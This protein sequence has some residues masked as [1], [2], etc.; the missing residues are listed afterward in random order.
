VSR[1]RIATRR[2]PLA[3]WQARH[4]A[5]LL[6]AARPG[7]EVELVTMDT[8][9]DLDLSQTIEAI[10]GKGAFSRE[11]QDLVLTGRA[12]VA[13][14]SAKDLQAVTP[15]GLVIA[16][17]PERGTVQDCLVGSRLAELRS[18]ARVA[19]GSNRRKALLLDIRPDLDVIGLR[20]NI[21]T[22]LAKLPDCDALVM[23]AVA[24]ERLG[25]TPDVVEAL[26]PE[27]FVPQVGQGALAVE[28]RAGDRE[29]IELLSAVDH[30]PT[31]LAVTAERS[32]LAELGGDCNLPAGAHAVGDADGKLTIRGVLAAGDRAPLH[33]ADVIDVA[34][35]DPG[36]LLAQRLRAALD[37]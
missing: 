10:G 34:S 35:A 33:R 11:I 30:G 5:Q 36:R 29:T 2:S 12:D 9:A 7:L 26:D 4:V 15:D 31:R 1:L 6:E 37:S 3:Q 27:R 13:V 18:G 14:H 32:F 22:R 16:A 8:A 20:G 23:A 21:G 28:A 25:E 19:T 17:Y 24:L